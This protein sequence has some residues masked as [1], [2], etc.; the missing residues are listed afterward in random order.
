MACTREDV[1]LELEFMYLTNGSYCRGEF[2]EGTVGKDDRLW[3]T[4]C[5][6][7]TAT[8]SVPGDVGGSVSIQQLVEDE[9]SC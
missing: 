3:P 2:T 4:V 6:G 7:E 1:Q 5:D 9:A 8:P